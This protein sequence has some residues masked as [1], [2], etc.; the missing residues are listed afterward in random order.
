MKENTKMKKLLITLLFAAG[1]L[2]A[3]TT[4][5]HTAKKRENTGKAIL[6]ISPHG[7]DISIKAVTADGSPVQVEGCTVTELPSDEE[8]ILTATGTKVV[9]KG[10][11]TELNCSYN[12]LTALDVRGLTALQELYC[13]NNML[14]SLDV[15]ELTG[16]HTLYCGKNWFTAL[17]IRGLTALQE[18]YCNDNEIA[19]LDARGLTALQ[20]LHCDNNRLT[21]LDVQGL[22]ALQEL[23]CSSNAIASIDV[24]GLT[25]LRILYC[26]N[27]RLT[28]LDVQGLTAL[29]KLDCSSNA[30]ASI[31][32]R[33]LTGLRMLYCEN[34]RLTSLDVQGLTAL[35][36]LVCSDN[37]LT[38][39]NVQ[40]LPA[41][42]ALVF[43]HNR[44]EEDA[45]I[46]ILNSLPERRTDEETEAVFYTEEDNQS[47]GNYTDWSSSAGLQAAIKRARA[48]NWTIYKQ[49]VGEDFE[50]LEVTEESE[51]GTGFGGAAVPI[52]KTYTVKDIRFVMKPIAAVQG[53]VLGDNNMEDN[54]EHSVSLSAYYIGETEVTQERQV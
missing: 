43:Q 25:G 8:T 6:G 50:E 32:V 3:C 33:G 18:L 4:A 36:L 15:R 52:D 28:S 22:T 7:K 48:K 46:R 16:L 49:T 13:Q 17:D 35:Q 44:L 20:A 53:A 14:T 38:A 10:D 51:R 24:R 54:Q 30:I 5:T 40:G 11:I 2:T 37:Q 42:Q 26:E 29:Q 12:E 34:N 9:L 27:N 39:L 45:L 23:D 1:L 21:S 31:D 41:L 47:E 19:S